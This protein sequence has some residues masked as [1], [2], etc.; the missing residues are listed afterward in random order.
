MAD[1]APGR[2]TAF[3]KPGERRVQSGTVTVGVA[4][5]D[6]R[7]DQIEVSGFVYNIYRI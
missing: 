5:S 6:W 7:I 2:E 1:D 4:G 3:N